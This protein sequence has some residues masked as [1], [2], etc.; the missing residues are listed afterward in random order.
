[1]ASKL[2]SQ[3]VT[4]TMMTFYMLPDGAELAFD[5]LGASHIGTATPLILVCG[6]SCLGSDWQ[7]LSMEL[8]N[9]RP[10]LVFD[11]RG[12]GQSKYSSVNKGGD[13]TIESMARDLLELIHWLGW[14]EIILCG[15][16]MGGVIIQQLLLL[17]HHPLRPTE[18]PFRVTHIL[19]TATMASPY[20]GLRLPAPPSRTASSEEKHAYMKRVVEGFF[21][22]PDWVKD[23]ANRQRVGWWVGHTLHGRPQ[24]TI[25]KQQRALV[26]FDFGSL[27]EKISEDLPILVIHGRVDA[28][29]PYSCG[30]GVL[31]RIPTARLVPIGDQPGSIPHDHFGHYWWEYFDI[32]VWR[33]VIE[34]FVGGVDLSG[35][36]QK[37]RL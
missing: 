3:P 4:T 5:V 8:S 11:H 21:F 22:D 32:G 29:L 31:K 12:I 37:A 16:S 28:I 26:K 35:E 30:E 14:K 1:M 17:P 9:I 24:H 36:S 20:F 10:V 15:F 18:L 25:R 27:H 2:N 19:L 34:V 13:I 7:R 33:D 23:E 6:M